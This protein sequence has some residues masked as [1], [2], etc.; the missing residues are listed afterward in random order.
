MPGLA[1][2]TVLS[3]QSRPGLV[4][5]ACVLRRSARVSGSGLAIAVLYS[6][7]R[8]VAVMSG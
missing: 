8:G 7:G 5:V 1:S 2:E 4:V 6:M 3:S